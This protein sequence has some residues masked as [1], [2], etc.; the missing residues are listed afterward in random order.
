MMMN[1][2]ALT[3]LSIASLQMIQAQ[4]ISESGLT[5]TPTND[6]TSHSTITLDQLDIKDLIDAGDFDAA[7]EIY[8]NGSNREGK[9]LQMMARIDWAAAGVED[10]TD[11]ESY[12]V[13]FRS[14]TGEPYLDSFNL[15]AMNCTG[16]FEGQSIDMC[17]IAA[18]KNLLCTGLNYAQY[19]GVKAIQYANEK[20]W[21]EMYAFWNGVYD[22]SIDIRVNSGGPGAVQKSRDS[23]FDTSFYEDAIQAFI[24]GQ[25]GFAPFNQATVEASYEAF[26]KANLASFAQATVKYAALFDEEGLEQALM[27]KKWGEGYTYFRCGAG[28]MDPELA[29]YIDYVLDPRDKKDMTFTPKET[30]CKIVNKMLSV[31]EIGMGVLVEDLNLENLFP[32]IKE[33][34]GISSFAHVEGASY[35]NK[36]N[37]N[38]FLP[39]LGLLVVMTVYITGYCKFTRRKQD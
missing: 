3:L 8:I 24:D 38:T 12:A 1:T 25:K 6:V 30:M 32:T 7:R 16:S 26:N 33:D 15:D 17:A 13:L 23:D 10:L 31:P 18:K 21:D 19:E 4:D 20:N 9:S 14:G 39:V 27:D 11:Y 35:T 2:F 37:L 5:F 29:L 34:C 28:L 36:D 22:E